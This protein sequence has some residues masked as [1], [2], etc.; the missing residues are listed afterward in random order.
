M[1]ILLLTLHQEFVT[2][3]LFVEFIVGEEDAGFS[4]NNVMFNR[5][6]TTGFISTSTE[7]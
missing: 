3:Q 4:Q 5:K 6:V 2:G 1:L 7:V